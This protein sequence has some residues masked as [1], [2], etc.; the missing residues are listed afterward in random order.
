MSPRLLNLFSDVLVV[1][2]G[3]AALVALVGLLG[4]LTYGRESADSR[5]QTSLLLVA[6][7][8]AW[9]LC[10]YAAIRLRKA[11]RS[12][13]GATRMTTP[14]PTARREMVGKIMGVGALIQAAGLVAPFILSAIAGI[15]GAIAGIILMVV[16][17]SIGYSKAR[18]WRCGH[19]K[20]S[21]ANSDVQIC[22]TCYAHL[23]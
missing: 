5:V 13:S 19:C 22:P 15:P 9:G 20:N 17:L 7:A 2:G 4:I 18:T 12:T 11:A 3:I 23:Q 1:V 6:G 16:L 10:L 14:G 21:I 8:V